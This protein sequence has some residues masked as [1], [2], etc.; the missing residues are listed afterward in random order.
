MLLSQSTPRLFGLGPFEI[1]RVALTPRYRIHRYTQFQTKQV[2]RSKIPSWPAAEQWYAVLGYWSS[3]TPTQPH[4]PTHQSPKPNNPQAHVEEIIEQIRATPSVETYV[5]CD[6]APGGAIYRRAPG[7]T[8]ER[9]AA[10]AEALRP[11]ASKA[12]GVVRD[13]DPAVRLLRNCVC[14]LMSVVYGVLQA[15]GSKNYA[16]RVAV[17]ADQDQEAG[18]HNGRRCVRGGSFVLC[19]MAIENVQPQPLSPPNITDDD[20]LAIILQR[21]A[22]SSTGTGGGE[23]P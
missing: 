3:S 18:A 16:E 20:F 7:T 11:V 13:L 1:D 15:D 19:D 2:P 9:A 22:P 21:W 8:E 4:D 10:V 12:Q 6:S 5:I 14:R 17:C 23:A